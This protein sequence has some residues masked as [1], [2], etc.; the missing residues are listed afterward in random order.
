MFN[1]ETS[2]QRA[3]RYCN[4]LKAKTHL[5]GPKKGQPLTDVEAGFRMG[6]VNQRTLQGKAASAA[7]N[8]AQ[9]Q[10]T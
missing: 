7:R 10:N 5:S 2:K 6:V 1:R 3:T 9:Q 8:R 4:E